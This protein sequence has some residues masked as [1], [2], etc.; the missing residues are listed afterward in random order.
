MRSSLLNL[1]RRL[2]PNRGMSGPGA[3]APHIVI[4][5]TSSQTCLVLVG[6]LRALRESG[7]H[8]TLIASPGPMLDRIRA[9]ERIDVIPISFERAIAPLAD[10]L[11]LVRLWRILGRLRPDLVE[12]STPKA[13]LLGMLAATL[14]RVPR[15]VYLLRGLKLESQRGLRRLLFWT[16]E[17]IA[18][19]CS[20]VILCNS[21]S[22]R[23]Q[24]IALHLADEAKLH[25]LG[26]GSSRGV[27]IERFSPGPTTVRERFGIPADDRVLGFVGRLTRDKGIP[28]LIDAFELILK[29]VPRARLLIVGWFDRA[30]DAIDA[31]LRR[32]IATHPR[33]VCT[34]FDA[35]VAPYYRA[36]D[37]LL[38]P[39][40]REGFPNVVLEASAS[41]IAVITTHATG[42]RD[43]VVPG[44]TGILAAADPR[45]IAD[46]ALRL[47][48]DPE[49]CRRM[50][51]AGRRRIADQF[52][53]RRIFGLTA[54]FYQDLLRPEI[55]KSPSKAKAMDLA[56]PLL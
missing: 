9:S 56:V 26:S 2:I 33:I 54:A 40:L 11:S 43:A 52:L 14:A 15:R 16:T 20:H 19:G 31:N 41:E 27:D 30:E 35:D 46:A 51:A 49:L 28:A 5:V 7:F 48:G 55:G 44:E 18:A 10:L 29:D 1:F 21:P 25:V 39:T 22:L 50:G 38:L 42:A 4:G 6:R 34:G 13:G 47:F 37:L 36:M 53:Q 24:A 12:F 32:R 45:S 8:V 3:P 17:R 23:E